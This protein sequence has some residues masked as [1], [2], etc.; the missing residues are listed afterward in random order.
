M[1]AVTK[2]STS[3]LWAWSSAS[4]KSHPGTPNF[5]FQLADLYNKEYNPTGR[6]A[7]KDYVFPFADNTFDFVFLTSVFTHM[8][9]EDV[10]HYVAEISRVLRPGGRCLITFFLLN[11]VSEELQ[12]AGKS[13][14][15]FDFDLGVCKAR[16]KDVHEDAIAYKEPYV[17]T[18]F[19]NHNLTIIEPIHYGSWSG[20]EQFLSYQ[21]IIISA[22]S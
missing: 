22:K 11:E 3:S 14:I 8:L 1:R 18:L 21:D 15:R 5:R 4:R 13:A 17:R 20:R 6:L 10:E 12:T 9:P 7:A 2:D 19:A 16:R